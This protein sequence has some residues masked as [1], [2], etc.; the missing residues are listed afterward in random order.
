YFQ[1]NVCAD[2][3][4]RPFAQFTQELFAEVDTQPVERM[5]VDLRFNGGGD[6]RVLQPFLKALAN[7]PHLAV[8]T[9]IGRSTF[10]SALM[11][12]IALDQQAAAVLVGEPT[13]GRPNHYGEVRRF[14]LPNA[15]LPISYAT[16]YFRMLD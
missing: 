6:S 3:P 12:A 11:N 4:D 5:V 1:Y 13:G 7:R 14:V 16:K 2:D 10:S 8:Y 15:K 9:L